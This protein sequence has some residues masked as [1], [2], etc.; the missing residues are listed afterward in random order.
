MRTL[1]VAILTGTLNPDLSVFL[2]CLNAVRSQT[3]SGKITHYILDGGSNK[4]VIDLT[5][6]YRCRVLYFYNDK[7][8]GL[9]RTYRILP[10]IREDLILFLESDNIMTSRYWLSDM[11]LPFANKK[12]FST[13]SM[14]NAYAK[15]DN[16]VTRYFAL[17]GAPDPTLYYLK[18]S[19]KVPMDKNTYDKGTILQNNKKY[20]IVRF[21]KYNQPVMGDNGFLIRTDVCRKAVIKDRSFYHTDIYARL[22]HM[23]YDTV[24]VVKNDIIHVSRSNMFDQV[25]RRVKVK[26]Y[27]TDELKGK[28]DYLVYDPSSRTDRFNLIIYIVCSLTLLQPLYISVK[29]YLKIKDIA[30]FLH[31]IMCY[32]M[33]I[34]YGVSEIGRI[35]K[36]AE[37]KL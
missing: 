18:K 5:K 3:Y 34:A 30:W 25:V 20:Y 16:I 21:S 9:S 7:N 17:I 28:R 19:D 6:Q 14:H 31:P 2:R 13:Y 10:R 22:L 24:A 29:G 8:E 12:I 35:W 27:F 23:G 11:I 32:F 26:E 1:S 33:V 4:N 37:K 36:F 15:T